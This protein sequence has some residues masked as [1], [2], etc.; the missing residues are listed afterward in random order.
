MDLKKLKDQYAE[1]QKRYHLP[2]FSALNHD[3][4][5]EKL[6]ENESDVLLREI[7]RTMLEKN[8]SYTRFIDMILNPSN[9][10][11]FLLI[12]LKNV[13]NVEKNALNEVYLELGKYEIRS[14]SLDNYYDEQK[15]ADFII[16]F[17]AEWQEIKKRF[18][19]I[20][21]SFEGSW[22]RKSEKREKGYLG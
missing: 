15:E 16:K 19:V 3:F 8:L 6:Q 22:D 9:A 17:F 21:E 13:N 10:P 18:S 2:E 5:I 14:L 11:M 12:L 7:R 4:D 1:L 20:L